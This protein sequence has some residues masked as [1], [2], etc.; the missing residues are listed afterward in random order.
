M[1]KFIVTYNIKEKGKV[2]EE[3]ERVVTVSDYMPSTMSRT[4]EMNIEEGQTIEV[5]NLME[6]ND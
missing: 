2:I 6:I 1:P 4:L 3:V 5:L